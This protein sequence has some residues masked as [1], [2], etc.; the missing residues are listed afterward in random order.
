MAVGPGLGG[1]RVWDGCGTGDTGGRTGE[2]AV[3]VGGEF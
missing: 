1:G 3:A 2:G